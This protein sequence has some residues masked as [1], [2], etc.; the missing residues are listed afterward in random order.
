MA[1]FSNTKAGILLILHRLLRQRAS[2]GSDLLL[3]LRCGIKQE[4]SP[5][6]KHTH[7]HTSV[8]FCHS[9]AHL[10]RV[11]NHPVVN[12]RRLIQVTAWSLEYQQVF[13]QYGLNQTSKKHDSLYDRKSTSIVYIFFSKKQY[14]IGLIDLCGKKCRKNKKEG[15]EK[16]EKEG[17]GKCSIQYSY[18]RCCVVAML[19]YVG[20]T[21]ASCACDRIRM[22]P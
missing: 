20:H 6:E 21:H 3:D 22:K 18:I 4:L 2:S 8:S 17:R 15:N 14:Y 5:A 19:D 13:H 7:T 12:S 10:T 9:H 11:E 1:E 16:E